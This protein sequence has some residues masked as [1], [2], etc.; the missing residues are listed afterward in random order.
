MEWYKLNVVMEC[1]VY[2]N[3]AA[4]LEGVDIDGLVQ[5]AEKAIAISVVFEDI[6]PPI[7]AQ[8]T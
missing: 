7:A 4:E 1:D 2:E 5:R 6:L 3:V 8:V